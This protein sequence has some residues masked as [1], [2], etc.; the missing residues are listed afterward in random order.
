L[1]A[2]AGSVNAQSKN[3]FKFSEAVAKY[4]TIYCRQF[5]QKLLS[6]SGLELIKEDSV[7]RL[8]KRKWGFI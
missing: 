5:I 2:L 6:R 8:L 7:L 1:A 4:I 3:S